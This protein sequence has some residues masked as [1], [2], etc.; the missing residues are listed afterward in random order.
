MNNINFTRQA[1]IKFNFAFGPFMFYMV[2]LSSIGLIVGNFNSFSY[3]FKSGTI[4]QDFLYF[5]IANALFVLIHSVRIV[6][7]LR[8]GQ[9]IQ[10]EMGTLYKTIEDLMMERFEELSD[11]N[12]WKARDTLDAL[13][14]PPI[15]PLFCF[16]L[17]QSSIL[18]IIA[19]VLTYLVVALQ[20]KVG[21]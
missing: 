2:A 3:F 4:T 16:L 15:T 10:D 20:F 21:E 13:D 5:S 12:L 18:S 14:E 6:T 11:K 17:N 1:T 9:T 19:T 8:I 7:Y